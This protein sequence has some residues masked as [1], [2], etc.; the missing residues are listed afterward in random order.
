MS[1]ALKGLQHKKRQN[2]SFSPVREL[3]AGLR[4]AYGRLIKTSSTPELSNCEVIILVEARRGSGRSCQLRGPEFTCAYQL[5]RLLSTW[6]ASSVCISCCLCYLLLKDNHLSAN[7]PSSN[8]FLPSGHFL[9]AHQ[10]L[11]H[12]RRSEDCFLGYKCRKTFKEP[13]RQLS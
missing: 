6:S 9:T 4:D 10:E 7:S 13:Q 2:A 5:R 11:H 12:G 8:P 1:K 3:A